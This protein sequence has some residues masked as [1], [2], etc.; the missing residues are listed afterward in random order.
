MEGDLL[1]EHIIQ[2]LAIEF[3]E[4]LLEEAGNLP[5]MGIGE[6]TD[7]MLALCKEHAA[8]ITAVTMEQ[9]D[10][11]LRAEKT[12]REEDGLVVHERNVSRN[13]M[14]AIGQLDYGRTC[15]KDKETG[16]TTYLLD[17]IIGVRS[18]ERVCPPISE[19]RTRGKPY[20]L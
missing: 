3:T 18:Y 5:G 11:V 20:V 12:Q 9:M 19:A 4:K 14:T 16:D 1:M 10:A 15:F 7:R 17:H 6:T 13:L 8:A 2:Q